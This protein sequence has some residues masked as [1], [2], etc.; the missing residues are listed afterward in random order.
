VRG[1]TL[2]ASGEERMAETKRRM[3]TILVV[4]GD[5][6]AKIFSLSHGYR[7]HAASQDPLIY[8]I[9]KVISTGSRN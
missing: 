9:W 4:D 2:E 3:G 8:R 5:P 6:I 7:G 1:P